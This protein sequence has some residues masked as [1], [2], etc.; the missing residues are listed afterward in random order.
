LLGAI[1]TMVDATSDSYGIS[2]YSSKYRNY[3][4]LEGE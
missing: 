4:Y 2:Y 1:Y 3:Y